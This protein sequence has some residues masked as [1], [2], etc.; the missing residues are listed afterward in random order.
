MRH[1]PGVVV[2]RIPCDSIAVVRKSFVKVFVGKVLVPTERVCICEVGVNL[3][4]PLEEPQSCFMLLLQGE[5]I[6]HDTPCLG[7]Q[8]VQ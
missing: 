1:T 8:P 2:A 7:A 6:S 4:R 5:A 3:Q